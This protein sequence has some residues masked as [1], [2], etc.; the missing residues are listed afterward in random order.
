MLREPAY[1]NIG[2]RVGWVSVERLASVKNGCAHEIIS[3]QD[4]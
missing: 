3:S 1:E 2:K 4:A